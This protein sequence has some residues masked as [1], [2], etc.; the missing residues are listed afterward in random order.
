MTK[1][2]VINSKSKNTMRFNTNLGGS[3]LQVAVEGSG[4]SINIPVGNASGE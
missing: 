3:T 4:V 2:K 1:L